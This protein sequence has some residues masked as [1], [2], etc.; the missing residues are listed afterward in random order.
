MTYEAKQLML[1][2]DELR[3]ELQAAEAKIAMLRSAV[4]NLSA[5]V[6]EVQGWSDVATEI[7]N[8]ALSHTSESSAKFLAGVR[9]DAL[10][11]VMNSQSMTNTGYI[12]RVDIKRMASEIRGG[13]K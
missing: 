8:S 9:A 6:R 5:E 4:L 12:H 13:A 7:V 2:I 3:K 11:D 1:E 10:E